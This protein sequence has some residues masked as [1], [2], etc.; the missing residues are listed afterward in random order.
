MICF[1][2]IV[3]IKSVYR[4]IL[5]KILLMSSIYNYERWLLMA[6]LS[7]DYCGVTYRNPLVLASATPGWDGEG[8]R[9]A[10]EAGI[11]G[12]IPKTIGPKQDWAA[13]PRN[14]RMY[15]HRH[16]GKPIGQVNMELFSTMTRDAWIDKELEIAKK[17]G[18][19]MHISVLAMPEPEETAK[20][21]E[22]L[23]ATGYVDL[24]E[25]NV[26][27]PMPASTVGMH[28][29]KNPSLMKEQIQAAKA[30]SKVP[31][32]VKLTPNDCDLVEVATVAK[33]AGADG[34]T[35]SNSIRSFAGVDIETGKPYLAG[36]GGYTGPA[37]RPVI[38]RKFSEVAR[39]VDIPISAVG[40]VGSYRDVVEFIMLGAST[41]Q[42]CTAVMWN[43]YEIITKILDDLNKWMDEKGYKSFDEIRGIALK[44]ITTVEKLAEMPP[45]SAKIDADKCTGCGLCKRSCFYRAI[46]KDGSVCKATSDCDGCGLCAQICPV[47][48]ITLN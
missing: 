3:I 18:A 38:M 36:Y 7:V 32:T 46:E 45:K 1:N 8:M 20:L 15:L 35:I 47:G 33:E 12:V 4:F 29:G 21:V 17:S 44:E 2:S 22:E 24:F 19:T 6:N 41:V 5:L 9:L 48:A 37:I 42:I 10:G 14:G 23:Q 16:N 30:V 27:C 26:S 43:G 39:N 13:H 11:G 40:G 28:I 31:F 34:L 25:L